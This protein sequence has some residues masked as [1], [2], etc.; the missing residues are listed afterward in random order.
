MKDPRFSPYEGK[1]DYIFV[2]Y[3]HKNAEEVTRLLYRMNREGFRIW[4][5]DGIA[6][7]SEWPEYIAHHLNDSSVCMA[8]VSPESIASANCRREIT[9]ALAKQKPFL[10]VFLKETELSPGMELQ[11]SAQQCILRYNFQ[12]EEEFYDKLIHADIL[13]SCRNIVVGPAEPVVEEDNTVKVDNIPAISDKDMAVVEQMKGIAEDAAHEDAKKTGKAK[14]EKKKRRKWLFPA[15]AGAVVLLAVL[16]VLLSKSNDVTIGST[17]YTG[18][19]TSI[20]LRDQ[21]ITPDTIE[22]L[23]SLKEVTYLDFENCNFTGSLSA[24]PRLADIKYLTLDHCT[25]INDYSFLPDMKELRYLTV[26]GSGLSDQ[27]GSL[28]ELTNLQKAVLN[29]NDKFTDLSLLPFGKLTSLDI[30]R[31]GVTDLAPLSKASAS[32]DTFLASGCRI[33]NADVLIPLKNLTSLDLSYTDVEGISALLSAL[34][35]SKLNLAGSAIKD[36]DAFDALTIL[37]SLNIS[38]TAITAAPCI[39][40]SSETLKI[41]SAR[42]CSLSAEMLQD[43]SACTNIE[44]LD[45]CGAAGLSDLSFAQKMSSL[46]TVKAEGCGL[47]TLKGLSQKEN[48]EVILAQN[49]QIETINASIKLSSQAIVDLRNNQLKDVSALPPTAYKFLGLSGNSS[50]NLSSIQTK[51]TTYT[52]IVLDYQ[53]DFLRTNIGQ[54]DAASHWYLVDTPPDQQLNIES[55]LQKYRT[56]FVTNEE[57]EEAIDAYGY[58]ISAWEIE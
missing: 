33:S 31:T 50:L 17:T 56:S 11:L 5:D 28:L 36:M 25:G 1:E 39:G 48:L 12:T 45:V 49:N 30:S 2:T 22:K 7:G 32:L 41:F 54:K 27:M 43:L 42:N 51:S 20:I 14:K 13:A 46:T 15:I 57:I 24:Y 6:A 44:V 19:E 18:K 52:A 58:S 23:G 47:K 21:E 35:I 8:L 3:A 38:D 34:S 29:D 9:Y 16:L 26:P 55:N 10:G 53:S 37:S 40:K 4:Y